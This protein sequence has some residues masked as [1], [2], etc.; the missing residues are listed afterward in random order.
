MRGAFSKN[1][2]TFSWISH[3][4]VVRF[5]W[6]ASSME[7]RYYSLRFGEREVQENSTA[8]E[9][10]RSRS[11]MMT[12]SLEKIALARQGPSESVWRLWL[13]VCRSTG[14]VEI[15][16]DVVRAR[17][18]CR[19]VMYVLSNGILCWQG[20]LLTFD[21]ST[22]GSVIWVWQGLGS[23]K[24]IHSSKS[25]LHVGVRSVSTSLPRGNTVDGLPRAFKCGIWFR[26]MK[27]SQNPWIR[28]TPDQFSR[29]R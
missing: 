22:P 21:C 23:A 13:G 2:F 26:K 10:P 1:I 28:L 12:L 20:C 8:R 17:A 29:L 19:A 3:G 7:L 27:I 5:E 25:A 6:K 4:S 11:G 16:L 14:P 15:P 18:P 24:V 9:R